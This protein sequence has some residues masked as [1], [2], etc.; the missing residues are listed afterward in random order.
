MS[1][2]T[3]KNLGSLIEQPESR[4]RNWSKEGL[5]ETRI[6]VAEYAVAKAAQKPPGTIG[7]GDLAGFVIRSSNIESIRGLA[8]RLTDVWSYGGDD[9][10]PE[11]N[12]LPADEVALQ[13]TNQSPKLERHPNYATLTGAQFDLVDLAIKAAT[14]A[15][16]AAAYAALPTLG[17]ELVDLIRAGNESYYLATLRY[18]WVTHSYSLPS[19]T[20]GGYVETVGGPLASYF[21][22]TI[23]WLREADN[24][25]YQNGIW[26]RTISWLGADAWNADIYP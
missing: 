17:K 11:V 22:G 9:G 3:L 14:D 10:D 23:A 12:P 13:A 16:R 20:R 26:R 1:S 19:S 2:A 21:I 18:S 7:S 25:D 24:L 5:T 8:A 6:Y 15:E 4:S